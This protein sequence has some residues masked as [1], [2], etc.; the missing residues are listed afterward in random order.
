MQRNAIVAIRAVHGIQVAKTSLRAQGSFG[1]AW[2]FACLKDRGF[3]AWRIVLGAVERETDM[4]RLAVVF[5][6]L[7]L[8]T[9][10]VGFAGLAGEL[11]WVARITFLVLL[12]LFIV[13]AAG[14]AWQSRREKVEE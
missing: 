9:A 12:V 4:Q 1:R 10:L 3:L 2:Q 5:L 6:L 8:V 7:A 14:S 11:E 13:S